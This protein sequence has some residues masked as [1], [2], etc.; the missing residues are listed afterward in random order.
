MQFEGTVSIKA[1]REDVWEFLTDPEKVTQ[2]VPG[3]ESFEIVE[4]GKKFNAVAGLGLG[5][6]KVKF[7]TEIEW[8]GLDKPNMARMHAKGTAPGSSMEAISEMHLENT[9]GGTTELRW[10]ADIKIFG[11]IA[12]LAARLMGGVTNKLSAAF[13]QCV[14]RKIEG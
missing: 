6:V 11:K 2:C 9:D 7:K 8:L 14:K 13:F 5:T 3:V 4:P 10:S 1:P 12:S